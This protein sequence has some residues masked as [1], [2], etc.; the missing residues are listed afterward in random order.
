[1]LLLSLSK[2]WFRSPGRQTCVG[3]LRLEAFA[4]QMLDLLHRLI[5]VLTTSALD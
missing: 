2:S 4:A 3:G 1:M 5:K